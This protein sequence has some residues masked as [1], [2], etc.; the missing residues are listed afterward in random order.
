MKYITIN[1]IFSNNGYGLSNDA[2]ILVSM[3]N[4]SIS[5]FDDIELKVRAV[6]FYSYETGN[7]DINFFLEIPNPLLFHYAKYNIL[8]PNPEWFYKSWTPYFEKI[9]Y[10]WC[11]TSHSYNIFNDIIDKSKLHLVGWTSIDKWK[12]HIK[13]DFNKYLH[14]AGKSKYKGTQNL[15]NTWQENWP[16]LTVIH[17][18]PDLVVK[19]Q[20]NITYISNRLPDEEL[21]TMMNSHGVHICLSEIEGFGHNINEAKSCKSIV[22]STNNEPMS[23]MVDDKF[24]VNIKEEIDLEFVLANKSIF[25]ENSLKDK[26]NMIINF[27]PEEYINNGQNNRNSFL[28]E[29]KQNRNLIIDSFGTIIKNIEN[30]K[31]NIKIPKEIKTCSAKLPNI[32]IITLTHNRK[33]FLPLM[34]NNYL[35]TDYPRDKL[36]WI[37]ID[38]GDDNLESLINDKKEE[39]DNLTYHKLSN[40]TSI[41]DKR[42]IG[43]DLAKYSVIAFMDDDDVYYPRHLL[44]RWAYLDFYKMECAYCT[45]IGC[46]HI[47]KLISHINVPPFHIPL[48]HRVSEASLIF[49]KS[50]WE[51]RKFTNI[52]IGEGSEFIKDRYD[53]C[54]EIPWKEI[55]ISLQHHKNI[56]NRITIGDKP[57]G[58]HF[59]I[60]DKLFAYLTNIV[61]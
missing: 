3:L 12:S 60:S 24:L 57:N 33:E 5:K 7:V 27:T 1:V 17:Q 61:Q 43:V 19:D 18:I 38:D 44:L 58:C 30:K 40:K 8:I 20:E 53:R 39:I 2:K 47:K 16:K 49:N 52:S 23:N 11:K 56:S 32:S 21:T 35:G 25:C 36:E 41:G 15:I 9:D 51:K 37:I 50:F 48:E 59:N 31:Y 22:I 28:A 13:K 55:I 10:V 54:I 34:I 14:C 42:N 45:T 26:I 29:M 4:Q 46:F 6:N